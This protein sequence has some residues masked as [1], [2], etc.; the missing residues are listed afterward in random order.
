MDRY[1]LACLALVLLPLV[2]LADTV[3]LKSRSG[4]L[5]LEGEIVKFDGSVFTLKTRMGVLQ[6]PATEV[7]CFGAGCPDTGSDALTAA[8]TSQ[9]TQRLSEILLADTDVKAAEDPGAA[10]IVFTERPLAPTRARTATGGA[11]N[12]VFVLGYDALVVVAG[13]KV[14]VRFL[15]LESMAQIFAGDVADWSEFGAPGLAMRPIVSM[16]LASPG[17]ALPAMM[18]ALLGDDPATGPTL[19]TTDA[20]AVDRVNSTPGAIAIVGQSAAKGAAALPIFGECGLMISSSPFEVLSGQYPLT[21]AFLAE[22]A[23][24]G[25]ADAAGRLASERLPALE[26]AGLLTGEAILADAGRVRE[27]FDISFKLLELA[28]G[29]Q[30]SIEQFQKMTNQLAGAR[31]LSLMLRGNPGSDALA[32]GHLSALASMLRAGEFAGHEV[33]LTGFFDDTAEASAQRAQ[34]VLAALVA[35][36]PDLADQAGV[37]FSVAG[38]GPIAPLACEDNAIGRSINQ[39]VEV[40][41]RPLS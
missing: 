7:D 36:T 32:R 11:A 3:V 25:A 14:P 2:S 30:G 31:R 27:W 17:G 37:R 23:G 24:A 40:W 41:L 18:S 15:T 33:I 21:R 19:V 34:S 39:R 16:E 8:G 29:D 13:P 26:A 6:V 10:D 4:F 38:F 9:A 20:D 22:A 1:V 28:G 12:Q 35:D 5:D